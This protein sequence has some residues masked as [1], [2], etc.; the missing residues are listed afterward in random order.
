MTSSGRPRLPLIVSSRWCGA[1]A[2]NRGFTLVEL[3]IVV[4]IVAIMAA[5]V[6]ISFNGGD[7]ARRLQVDAQ[8]L[9]ALLELTRTEAIR[10]NQEWG[11]YVEE[12]SLSFASFDERNRDWVAYDQRPLTEI[13]L[14]NIK[15]ELRV[16]NQLEVPKRF[17]ARN[18]PD[19][20]FFSS[21]ESMKF[22]LRLQP[23]WQTAAWTVSSDG[24]SRTEAKREEYRAL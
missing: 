3:L 18:V 2:C 12:S 4:V 7:R 22:D 8:R 24:L 14:E 19:L 16:D 9:A 10:R 17:D 20:V 6:T 21:G 5:T 15:L 1:G 23:D 13:T 11:V